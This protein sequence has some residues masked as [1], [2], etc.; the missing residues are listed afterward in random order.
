MTPPKTVR[1]LTQDELA[2]RLGV[3]PLTVKRWRRFGDGPA[4]LRVSR[5]RVVYRIADVEAW[6]K[7]RLV[8]SA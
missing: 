7:S 3:S 4:P 1:H 8:T 6:E 5:Q 2:E